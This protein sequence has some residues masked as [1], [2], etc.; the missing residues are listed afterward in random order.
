[1]L[2]EEYNFDG[3]KAHTKGIEPLI[4]TNENA[5]KAIFEKMNRSGG[6]ASGKQ[7]GRRMTQRGLMV[8]GNS[9]AGQRYGQRVVVKIRYVKHRPGMAGAG[10][11]AGGAN[12]LRDHLRYISRSGAGKDGEQAVL[13]NGVDEGVDRKE[14]F[15]LC[16]GDRHHF[17]FIISP[18]NGHD[19]SDFHIYIRKV[20]AL[21]EKDLGSKLEWVSAAHFDTEDPHAHVIVRGRDGRGQDLVIGSDYIKEGVRKRAQEVATELLGERSLED[22]QKS[23]EKEVDAL[24]VTSLDRFIEKQAQLAEGRQVDVRKRVNF[25]K[26]VFYEGVIKGRLQFLGQAGLALEQPPGVY[27]LKEDYQETL[28][29]IATRNEALKKLHGKVD[30]GLEGLSVYA[31]KAGQGA[32][33]EGRVVA[34]GVHD[35]LYDRKFVVLKE[36]SGSLHYIPVNE[37]KDYDQLET[38]SVIKVKPGEAGTG[39]ADHN[40]SYMARLNDGIYDPAH[41]LAHVEQNQSYITAK[42]RPRYIEAHTI[43]LGT[44]EAN[45]VVQALGGGRY[46]VPSDVVARGEEITR[47]I[48]EREKKRF[49]PIVSVLSMTPPEKQV[50]TAKKTWLDREIYKQSIGK[51]LSS[52]TRDPVVRDALEQRKNWLIKHDLALIQSNGQFALRDYAL[53]RLDKLEVYTAGRTLAAK[54]G[55]SF[56]DAQVRVDTVM[57]YEGFVKLETGVWATVTRDKTLQLAPVGAEPKL[58]RGTQVVFEPGPDKTL[59]IKSVA[60]AQAKTRTKDND[61]DREL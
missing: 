18:E 53:N 19:I 55:V 17:R 7:G 30:L 45:G 26:S 49:Y 32:V 3:V 56:S 12:A 39:K 13:F 42:E 34:K 50:E 10:K 1:M 58:E 43:R 4:V 54:M 52:A 57:R 37:F 6:L 33:L 60:Q 22:I 51:P 46:Q 31:L 61:Q 11:S 47:Q 21:V 23:L 25:G 2:L 14:F 5:R 48:N 41:H 28:G 9:F 16:E 44:L 20:M 38:G 36:P 40:I 59:I 24:R 8:R 29:Q 15:A 27:T 35:E